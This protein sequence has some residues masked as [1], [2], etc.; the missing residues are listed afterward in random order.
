MDNWYKYTKL[1]GDEPFRDGKTKLGFTV[2]DFWSY[3][4]S[5]LIDMSGEIA[6]FLVGRA[7][8]LETPTNKDYWRPFDI[9]YGD[10]RIEVKQTGYT[11][12]WTDYQSKQRRFGIQPVDGERNNDI[13]V[14]C[15]FGEYGETPE[16]ADPRDV[17]RWKFYVVPTARILEECGP[18]QRS[19][20]LGRIFGIG[21]EPVTFFE[22]KDEVDRVVASIRR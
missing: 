1:S 21:Y 9:V 14:F 10:V 3:S 16:E 18:N 7:L 11:H 2:K 4:Y 5:N 20:S 17:S 19:I 13:Y 8:G 12:T 22:L 15:L 6:E